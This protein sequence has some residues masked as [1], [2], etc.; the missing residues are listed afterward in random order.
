M[1]ELLGGALKSTELQLIPGDVWVRDGYARG[2]TDIQNIQIPMGVFAGTSP[3]YMHG[4]P[5]AVHLP[6]TGDQQLQSGI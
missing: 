2:A 5:L 1:A 4:L 6:Y 3:S